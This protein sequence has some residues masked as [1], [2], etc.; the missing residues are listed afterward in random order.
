MRAAWLQVQK[1]NEA[2]RVIRDA[3]AAIAISKKLYAATIEKMPDVQVV[4]ITRPLLAKV[5]G[6]PTTI[7]HQL[8]A[9][10]LPAAVFSGT[11]RR[12][13]R[14]GGAIARHFGAE[15][16]DYGKI[17][18]G[19]NGGTLTAAPDRGLPKDLPNTSGFGDAIRPA[20]AVNTMWLWI[21][22]ALIVLLLLWLFFAPAGA[23]SGSATT[24][25]VGVIAVA[26]VAA[27]AMRGR[28]AR[29]ERVA[30]LFTDPDTAATQLAAAPARPSFTLTIPGEATRSA[31]TPG[32][33]NG[34]SI[35]G[36]RFRTAAT[37]LATIAAIRPTPTPALAEFALDNAQAKLAAAVTPRTAHG[38][39]LSRI[40]KIRNLKWAETEE[41]ITE[42]M[43]YPDIGEPMY[44]KLVEQSDELLLPNLKLIPPN[45]IS[46]LQ[47]NQKVIESYMV[48][49]NHEM[50]RELLWREY[51]TDQRGSYFRQFWDVSGVVKPTPTETA[52][53]TAA[54]LKDITPI[55]TWKS[56]DKLGTHNNRDQQRDQSQI[57]LVI[58]GD[59]LKRYPNSV[60]F[61]QK[62]ERDDNGDL[63]LDLDL[64]TAEFTK[65]LLFPLYKAE[66]F[67]DIKFFGF[68]LTARQAKGDD[69]S[70]GFP[71]TDKDGWFF[72]IQEVP[73]EPRFGMDISYDPGT[74]GVSWDDI[75]WQNFPTPD[76]AFITAA[77]SPTGFIP[78]DDPAR[79]ATTSANMAY[80]L[81]Q[82]P[83]M[84]AVH[85]SEMLDRLT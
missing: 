60:I 74:D 54:D 21:L 35:E 40:V 11:F 75:S 58:R 62:A 45:T 36:Q 41:P 82:K 31:P 50:G 33:V 22:L 39:R 23:L 43:V 34:D 10:R 67:P 70:P 72:V 18:H 47:T 2:N 20:S 57:V 12:L 25:A 52:A 6:S 84:V 53:E 28:T 48:G 17:I 42:V 80:V 85:A 46:L 4:A 9:S 81:F 27:L 15:R 83:S 71:A 69:P 76:P 61:A 24:L 49:L 13:M 66:I 63:V 19:I 59:L 55:H 29:R 14:P 1:V 3:N 26:A 37:A 51:P 65:E 16:A 73:G 5:M 7:W 38:A 79:W 30:A 32:G 8:G 77:P 64:T 44:K 78:T 68:D 56:I